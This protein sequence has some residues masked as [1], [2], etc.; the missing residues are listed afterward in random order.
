MA[1][2][3][4]RKRLSGRRFLLVDEVVQGI[5]TDPKLRRGDAIGHVVVIPDSGHYLLTE[6]VK[7]VLSVQR[8]EGFADTGGRLRKGTAAVS[9]VD[10]PNGGVVG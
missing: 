2:M 5:D 10:E 6:F 7:A 4:R 9:A 3:E 8:R 1:Q